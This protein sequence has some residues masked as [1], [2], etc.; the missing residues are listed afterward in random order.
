MKNLLR[1]NLDKKNKGLWSI[2]VIGKK[3]FTSLQMAVRV[4]SLKLFK[5]N[6]LQKLV[7]LNI[8]I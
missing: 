8:Y 6:Q 5:T 4:A 7:K 3:L 2:T 1:P